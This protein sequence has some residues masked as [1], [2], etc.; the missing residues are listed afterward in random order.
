M[1]KILSSFLMLILL[2]TCGNNQTAVSAAKDSETYNEVPFET[3]K[4]YFFKKA[5]TS[6]TSIKIDNAEL[7][8]NLFGMAT[9][10]GKDGKP[11]EIDFTKQFVW[12]IVLPV[13]DV[14]TEIMPIRVEERNDT[15]F[16][17][18][19]IKTGEKLSYSIEPL[20][21]II[22]DKKYKNKEAVPISNHV[23]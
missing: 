1:K 4:N 19:E 10:M 20:S 22:L 13:T 6:P 9:T 21:I 5:Q 12:A 17:H 18:Y 8:G 3:A 23:K 11:T 14:E 15:L 7:F 2:T 16:Y